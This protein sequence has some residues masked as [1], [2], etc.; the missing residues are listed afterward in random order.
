MCGRGDR[1]GKRPKKYFGEDGFEQWGGYMAAKRA[2]LLDQFHSE[3]IE[4]LSDIFAGVR[5]MV[6]G[7]TKPPADELK[8]LMAA[9]G[10][11]YHMYQVSNTTHIIA[12]N[13]PNVKIKQL[14]PVPIVKPSW[15]TDSI[16]I[17]KLLDYRRYLLYT[18]QSR[19]QPALN[20]PVVEK[21]SNKAEQNTGETSDVNI[22]KSDD[23][24]EPSISKQPARATKTASDPN[25]LEEF[26][27]NS[28]LHLISTLGAE[29]KQLVGQLREKSDGR[30]PGKEKLIAERDTS[31]HRHELHVSSIIMHI[32]MD[33]FFASVGLRNHPE[34]K[35]KPVA[36]T[37]A[38]SGVI[39]S[40]DPAKQAIRDQ[41]FAMY[42]QRL[43]DGVSSRV[44]DIKEKIDGLAS[45]SEIASC[46]Y[47]ARQFGIKNGMFLGQA[48]KL[49][50]ELKTLPYDFE[51]YKEVSNILYNTVASYTLD[52]EAVSCDEMYVDVRQILVDA[53][54]SVEEWACHIREEIMAKTGCPCST[55][56]GANR[57]QARLATR[58]A[59]PAGQYYLKPEE[60]EDY[61]ADIPLPD[62]PG[63]GKAT[64]AKLKHLGYN[65][66]G[67]LQN[68]SLKLLQAELGTKLGERIW[69]QAHGNDNKPLDYNH[70]R[71]SVSAEINYGIRFK[72]KEECYNFL[73]SLANE[74]YSRLSDIN[75]KARGLTLKL[76]VRAQGAPV[77][78]AKF[79]GHGVCDAITK[80]STS[81]LVYSNADIIF[82]EA[83]SIYDKLNVS[84][85]ELRG[86]GIQLTKL[87]KI[88]QINKALSNFLKQGCV[89]KNENPE[90]KVSVE[91]P[92]KQP[93]LSPAKSVVK[94]QSA[95]GKGK[96]SRGKRGG[97]GKALPQ[98][99]TIQTYLDFQTVKNNSDNMTGVTKKESGLKP[100][101]DMTVLNELP[102]DIRAEI[103]KEYGLEEDLQIP[104]TSAVVQDAH[105]YDEIRVE[106]E[107]EGSSSSKLPPIT[108]QETPSWQ[109]SISSFFP[110]NGPLKTNEANKNEEAE[111][112]SDS[113]QKENE[114][115]EDE[116]EEVSPAKKAKITEDSELENEEESKE[117]A[118]INIEIPGPSSSKA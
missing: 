38:K 92:A 114:L 76:L 105:T 118:E 96:G 31:N 63:V 73:R 21:P 4:K 85:A 12:S 48:V 94:G 17:N 30:F 84:Y 98:S 22:F 25:F 8:K 68:G 40:S 77:E 24:E 95:R 53:G 42:E 20:F 108:F 106:V 2:K 7:F 91:T 35:G 115:F 55:G 44:V 5:I 1:N 49:C 56:F 97:K 82:K 51:G 74:V 70:E 27:S 67:D 110:T 81:T 3:N 88:A 54:M 39:Q 58:K 33:C 104:S 89:K 61:M 10:G 28:R 113:S 79:L 87:E 19:L 13:L 37:H 32:D 6:N 103:L 57:L 9:H 47:E 107:P 69:D 112:S 26:Y 15:I 65:T 46:T 14:G 60:V 75:M 83:K 80:S 99:R 64:L 18:N 59:K 78:T 62:L 34:L 71:K 50:P 45:M 111:I 72:T 23:E 116:S 16:S 29:F 102:A 100:K 101:I 41:E 36:I 66:C 11:E 52:I 90:P 109:K 43:P 117:N 86:V 93:V